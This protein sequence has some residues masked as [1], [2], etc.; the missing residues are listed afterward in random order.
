M[1]NSNINLTYSKLSISN[2]KLIPTN[3]SKYTKKGGLFQPPTNHISSTEN[4]LLVSR[5]L[6]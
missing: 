6:N 2:K 1:M 5:V 4:F 3:I